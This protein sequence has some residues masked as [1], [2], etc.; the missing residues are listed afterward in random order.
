M[1]RKFD[2]IL[3][4]LLRRSRGRVAGLHA[5]THQWV[6]NARVLL[7]V[8][9]LGFIGTAIVILAV[10]GGY[11]LMHPAMPKVSEAPADVIIQPKYTP[12]QQ[13]I[14]PVDT[15]SESSPAAPSTD[16]SGF[17]SVPD[18]DS[19]PDAQPSSAVV[20]PTD[21]APAPDMT[22]APQTSQA[23]PSADEPMTQQAPVETVPDPQQTPQQVPPPVV[24][25]A[26]APAPKPHTHT[27]PAA[28]P[29]IAFQPSLPV[30]ETRPVTN[31]SGL[32]VFLDGAPTGVTAHMVAGVPYVAV[33]PIAVQAGSGVMIAPGTQEVR[34]GGQRVAGPVR[35]E[36]LQVMVPA[37]NLGHALGRTVRISGEKIFFEPS[38]TPAAN[39][40]GSNGHVTTTHPAPI[41]APAPVP[42][43]VEPP[44][45]TPAGTIP[46]AFQ[47]SI[48]GNGDMQV[49]VT[50]LELATE[51]RNAYHPSDGHQYAIVFASVQ[52]TSQIMQVSQGKFTL[53]DNVGRT[54]E[55]LDSLSTLMLVV[56]RP[57]GINYGY[58]VFE[59]PLGTTPDTFTYVQENRA[60][61]NVVLHH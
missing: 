43:P 14:Q 30:P 12:A 5:P 39:G 17:V 42:Q 33:D 1:T 16:S 35:M 32:A 18:T 59:V 22:A 51:F 46:E 23:G 29:R 15:T 57:G 54:Y 4:R 53:R 3:D 49:T 36:G 9:V 58:L 37:A 31:P 56:L 24:T 6:W 19:K 13:P 45:E 26:P 52:N 47:P 55:S 8:F 27:H 2:P 60:P 41:Q 25:E 7:L 48:A 44:I 50:N 61:L 10:V 40:P 11:S 34:V 38:T 20:P 28:P 21:N